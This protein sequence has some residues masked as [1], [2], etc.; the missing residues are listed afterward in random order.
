MKR[1]INIS[2]SY[3]KQISYILKFEQFLVT[4]NSKN[5]LNWKKPSQQDIVSFL[6]SVRKP[7]PLDPYHKWIGTYNTYF[8]TLLGFFK[9]LY[10]PDLEPSKRPKPPCINGISVL[11]QKEKSKYRAT[12]MWSV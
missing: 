12:D 9:W 3:V 6:D 8:I 4:N 10:Y 5:I 7:E 2:N 11:R 1:E